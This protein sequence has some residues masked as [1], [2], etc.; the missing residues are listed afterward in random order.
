[1]NEHERTFLHNGGRIIINGAFVAFA[2]MITYDTSIHLP[3]FALLCFACTQPVACCYVRGL[4]NNAVS[5][6]ER[7]AAQRLNSWGRILVWSVHKSDEAGTEKAFL[8]RGEACGIGYMQKH[9]ERE[10]EYSCCKHKMR[11]RSFQE[12]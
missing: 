8:P 11:E 9:C 1:M 3:A 12:K 7:R 6:I 5:R 10:R 4:S 2:R